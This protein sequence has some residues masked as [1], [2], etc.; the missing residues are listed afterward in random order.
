MSYTTAG[1]RMNVWKLFELLIIT[2]NNLIA[3]RGCDSNK[4]KYQIRE[5][6]SGGQ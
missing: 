6:A 2:T 5:P 3:D 1:N 4:N